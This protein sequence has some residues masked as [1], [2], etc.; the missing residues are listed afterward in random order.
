MLN[1][2]A[3]GRDANKEQRD[4]FEMYD[5]EHHIRLKLIESLQEHFPHLKLTY[6]IGGQTSFDILP[7]VSIYNTN[8]N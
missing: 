8:K 3:I 5:K 6:L 1:I 7:I 2:C 4:F